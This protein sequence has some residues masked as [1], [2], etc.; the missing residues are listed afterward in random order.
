M[1]LQIIHTSIDVAMDYMR[2]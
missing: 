1:L 2:L